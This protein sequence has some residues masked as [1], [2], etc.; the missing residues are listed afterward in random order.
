[1]DVAEPLL[2][3]SEHSR[4]LLRIELIFSSIQ[5]RVRVDQAIADIML[6]QVDAIVVVGGRGRSPT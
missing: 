2:N 3:I 4:T 5:I 1:V 6:D